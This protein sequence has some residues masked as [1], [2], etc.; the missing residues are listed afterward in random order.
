MKTPIK[1]DKQFNK[2]CKTL[3]IISG[4]FALIFLVCIILPD[5]KA[6][7]AT[8]L[9][10]FISMAGIVSIP[11]FIL[12][13]LQY[14]DSAVY[15][16]RL[17]KNHF[18][19]P[20]RKKDYDND[21]SNLPRE[22]EV[23]NLYFRDS[24]VSGII[25]ITMYAIFILLDLMYFHKWKVYEPESAG[26]LL[27]ILMIFHTIFPIT[28]FILRRQ[29]DR[30][31]YV[32]NVD[33]RD[34]R[35]ARLSITEAMGVLLILCL[36]AAYSVVCAHTMT[37]Y[38]YKSK[39]GNYD[40][41]LSR[42]TDDATLN[43]TSEDLHDGRWDTAIT[44]TARG[45]NMSPRLSFDPVPGAEYYVIYMVDESANN[46][47][48]WIATDIRSTDLDSGENLKHENDP[49]F[50]YRGPY[51]PEGSGD[52]TYTIYVYA[53]KK[54]PDSDFEFEFDEPSLQGDDLYYDHLNISQRGDI[55]TYGNVIAYGYISG[56]YGR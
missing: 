55:D 19:L 39:N 51:P 22:V 26:A 47:V 46:W 13:S 21:L 15:L 29:K 2:T 31:R 54:A 49:S 43:V 3:M 56:V 30:D 11:V 16:K 20:L 40:K 18:T 34:T 1:Y 14:I 8:G 28:A 48:H 24:T 4:I 12:S 10:I 17:E 42:F 41:E 27:F 50:R 5:I 37:R 33:I 45:K 44:D 6:A 36:I 32:D 53:L 25:S 35:K 9:I 38:V 7:D 23:N 52:H